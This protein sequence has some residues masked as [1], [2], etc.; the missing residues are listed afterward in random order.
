MA[1]ANVRYISIAFVVLVPE[2]GIGRLSWA[3]AF[4]ARNEVF[5][6]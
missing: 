1:A 3:L 4:E 5:A 6:G 2:N